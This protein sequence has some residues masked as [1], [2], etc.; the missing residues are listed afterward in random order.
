MHNRRQFLKLTFKTAVVI[1]A[2]NVLQSFTASKFTFPP[3][4]DISLRFAIA[5]D[6]HYGQ[7]GTEY[8]ALHD[9]MVAWIN[10]EQKARG[11]DFTVINGDLFHDNNAML[12]L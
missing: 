3:K 12:P 7:E 10:A 11:I 8:V 5:S 6:G 2:G 9:E 4:S 1:S